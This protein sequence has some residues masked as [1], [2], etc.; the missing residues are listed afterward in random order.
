MPKNRDSFIQE[1][2]NRI[3]RWRRS[4][5]T[6]TK[7]NVSGVPVGGS[8]RGTASSFKKTESAIHKR[9]RRMREELSGK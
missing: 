6:R 4:R 9:N 1:Q 5:K 3:M 2:V 7:G 8:V